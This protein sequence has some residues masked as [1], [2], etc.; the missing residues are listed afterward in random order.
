MTE[1]HTNNALLA[2]LK[3]AGSRKLTAE[4]LH[5][6]RVSF[7]LGSLKDDSTVTRAQINKA[8]AEQEGEKSA[9]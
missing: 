4:E 7:I 2:K 6:Q 9:A 3:S 8:L 1:L 5:K